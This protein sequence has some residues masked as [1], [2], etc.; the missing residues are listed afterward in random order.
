MLSGFLI[1]YSSFNDIIKHGSFSLK[2]YFIRR[3]L[4]T[5]PLYFLI[6]FLCG[7]SYL[8]LKQFNKV[9]TLDNYWSYFFFLH[10]YFVGD[11]LFILKNLWAMAVTEQ[12]YFFWGII[13]LW[14]QKKI[15][16][17]IVPLIF[18]FTVVAFLLELTSWHIYENTLV[19]AGIYLFGVYCGLLPHNNSPHL[20]FICNLNKTSSILFI[21]LSILVASLGF[22]ISHQLFVLRE[23][24]L[25]IGFFGFLIFLCYS[26]LKVSFLSENKL[27]KYLGK[28]SFGL[29][30]YHAIV[31][32]VVTQFFSFKKYKYS[33]FQL[34]VICLLF[35]VLLSVASY[36]L[37][38]KRFLKIK[39]SFR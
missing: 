21:L 39:Q 28:I 30:C 15:L 2:R 23:Y 27:I 13:M 8:L 20:H 16:K 10:N 36:E 22:F 5:F 11:S 6:V 12:L 24:V 31:I 19:Y 26:R 32:T 33:T 38:E 3:I 7:L 35:T 34:F 29:Y 37:Y 25:A 17:V 18:G 4:R 14:L 9:I 1:G